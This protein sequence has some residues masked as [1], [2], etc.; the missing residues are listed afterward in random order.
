MTNTADN[1]RRASFARGRRIQEEEG[2]ELTA[3]TTEVFYGLQ[4]AAVELGR[5][6]HP[7]SPG[8]DVPPHMSLLAAAAHRRST[9]NAQCFLSPPC[10]M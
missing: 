8:S 9:E 4:E 6:M 5:P 3:F 1:K 10:F 2:E 7:R